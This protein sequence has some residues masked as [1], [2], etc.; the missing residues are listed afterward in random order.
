[1]LGEYTT[2]AMTDLGDKLSDLSA[3]ARDFA[4]HTGDRYAAGL[5]ERDFG[6]G[7]L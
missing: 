2:R 5:W 6:F 1:M 3:L 4:Q 7:L